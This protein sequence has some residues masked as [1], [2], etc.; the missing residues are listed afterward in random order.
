MN[1]LRGWMTSAALM[2]TCWIGAASARPGHPVPRAPEGVFV[3]G[4]TSSSSRLA[5][6][7][8]AF[9][10]VQRFLQRT[11]GTFLAG[12][13]GVRGFA[14][15]TPSYLDVR[16]VAFVAHRED[17]KHNAVGNYGAFLAAD[18]RHRPGDAISVISCGRPTVDGRTSSEPYVR[19]WDYRWESQGGQSGWRPERVEMMRVKAC[20]PLSGDLPG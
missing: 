15:P 17:M 19:R 4:S 2:T 3:S 5:A 18:A 1:V 16:A 10:A 9:V 14:W 20:L 8:P 7:T 6:G 11:A 12:S 13:P